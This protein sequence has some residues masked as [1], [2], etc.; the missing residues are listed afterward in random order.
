MD[1]FDS[2]PGR[3]ALNGLQIVSLGHTVSAPTGP[4]ILIFLVD[5]MGWQDTSVAFD[6]QPSVWNGLYSTP[7]MQQLADQGMMLTS[8]YSAS[9][10][11]SPSRTSLLTGRNP[12]RTNV[13]NWLSTVGR[14]DGNSV[15]T[16]PVWN[17]AG[18]Q[19]GDGNTTIAEILRAEGYL[20]ANVGKAHLGAEFTSGADPTALG[21]DINIGGSHAGHASSYSPDYGGFYRAPGF[22]AYSGQGY[23]FYGCQADDSIGDCP[24]AYNCV[25]Q[26]FEF[27]GTYSF[28]IAYCP[29][30]Y[31]MG[32]ME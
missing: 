12:G 2:S 3:G 27:S 4:N 26:N 11:C 6:Q 17:S 21:F 23:C 8:A 32:I 1:S 5:D 20:T 31:E 22:E 18:L 7:N 25:T 29:I 14:S 19:P 13:T 28:C 9:P 15:L 30:F 16:D 24:R 10:V